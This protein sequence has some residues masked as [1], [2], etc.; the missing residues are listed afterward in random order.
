[1]NVTTITDKAAELGY[2]VFIEGGELYSIAIADHDSYTLE[3][4]LPRVMFGEAHPA[5]IQTTAFGP[6][7]SEQIDQVIKAYQNAQKMV[8]LINEYVN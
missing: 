7:T 4:S 6:Q 5:T 1:M 3:V 8:A 2:V